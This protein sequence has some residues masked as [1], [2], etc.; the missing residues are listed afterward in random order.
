MHNGVVYVTAP[1]T[2][3]TGRALD[4]KRAAVDISLQVEI[5]ENETL[6]G[7][8]QT[9]IVKIKKWKI[10]ILSPRRYLSTLE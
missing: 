4:V 3:T 1:P 5:L 10:A 6:S 8:D 2:H 9:E 7:A